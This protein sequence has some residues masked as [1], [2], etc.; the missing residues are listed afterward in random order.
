MENILGKWI[1][2]KLRSKSDSAG[3]GRLA[4]ADSGSLIKCLGCENTFEAFAN[5]KW[6]SGKCY[7]KFRRS[8]RR[9]DLGY[10]NCINCQKYFLPTSIKNKLCS[11]TCRTHNK[12]NYFVNRWEKYRERRKKAKPIWA[13]CKHCGINYEITRPNRLYCSDDC[14]NQHKFWI[15]KKAR[16]D[17]VPKLRKVTEKDIDS[18][19]FSEEIRAFKEKGKKIIVFPVIESSTLDVNIEGEDNDGL[20]DDLYNFRNFKGEK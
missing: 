5:K 13:R 12:R 16:I 7:Q 6:C 19:D 9:R 3:S 10:I 20:Q 1:A 15:K 2:E 18:S 14:R 11:E 8:Q 17:W 4:S